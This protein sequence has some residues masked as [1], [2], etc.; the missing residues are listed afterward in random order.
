M[1]SRDKAD[2]AVQHSSS[3][4]DDCLCFSGVSDSGPAAMPASLT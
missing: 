3:G 4:I 2:N 1:V